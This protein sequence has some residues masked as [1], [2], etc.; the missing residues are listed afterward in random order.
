MIRSTVRLIWNEILMSAPR[1]LDR[2]SANYMRNEKLHLCN[3]CYTLH[4]FRL[5]TSID[6]YRNYLH[7]DIWP[8]FYALSHI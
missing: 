6:C 5:Q 7:N 2:F 3:V 8:H 4:T 1:I